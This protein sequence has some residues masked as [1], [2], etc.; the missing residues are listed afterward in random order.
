M[1][2]SRPHMSAHSE[3]ASPTRAPVHGG[4]AE[5]SELEV[6][7]ID[8]FIG[9]IRLLGMPK[10]VG[11]LYG[12]LFVSPT[13]LPMEALM[14]RL[15]MSKGSASQG[16]KLLRSFGAVKTVY[17]AG[18]R[19]DHYVAEFDLS[20]FASN[21]IKGEL[22]P[23]LDSGLERIERMEQ[24]IKQSSPGERETAENRL[25][26]LRHWHEKGQ[27]MLPWVLKFLVS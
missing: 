24:L 13:P 25:A 16:L 20:R 15:Q 1:T 18:D 2:H 7:A 26:R 21:F 19:R 17:V 12:L 10:S 4:M 6:E 23:H 3:L 8:L 27:S 5:L 9:L 11:E 22:Q 14:D